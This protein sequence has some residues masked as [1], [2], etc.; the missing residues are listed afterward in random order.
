MR[1]IPARAWALIVLSALLQVMIF[2]VA[3]A[4]PVWRAALSWVALVPLLVALLL[5]D[6]AGKVFTMRH[7]G[8]LGYG[9][10]ILWYM[11][12]CYWIYPTMHE[13]GGLPESVSFVILILFSMYLG[14]YHA[15]FAFLLAWLRRSRLG[16]S[17]ALLLSP[18]V[19][20]S[21][22]LARSR[23]TYF[24]W[25]LLG[26]AQVD[27]LLLT[28]LAPLGGVMAI[29]FVLAG[30]NALVASYF[31]TGKKRALVYVGPALLI[32]LVV[33]VG[34][35]AGW[36]MYRNPD[37]QPDIAVMMQENIEVG[38]V[39]RAAGALTSTEELRQFSAWSLHPAQ[40][41][42]DNTMLTWDTGGVGTG[43]KPATVMVWPEAPAHLVSSDPVFRESMGQLARA[44]QAPLVIGSLGV[45]YDRTVERGYH[46]YDSA[47]YF[48]ATGKYQDRYDKIHLVPFGE[49][50]PF[51][52]LFSFAHKLTEGVGDTDRGWRRTLFQTGGHSYGTMICY[53]SV[54]GDEVRQFVNDG[55][56]VLVNI[57][58]DAWYGDSSAPWQT[59][60]M[61]RMR[62]IEN[63]RW[64]LR[65]TN[66]GITAAIDPHGRIAI[67]APRHVR[68]A[69]AFPFGF[70]RASERTLYTRD[71]DWF[72]GLCVLV[73]AMGMVFALFRRTGFELR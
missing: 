59:L 63:D 26:Y 64:V 32:I 58:N 5:G 72:A 43:V 12:N 44:G 8:L 4:L 65:D 33:Q 48:D 19:W 7:A 46:V 17:G 42:L 56:E 50:M 35:Y 10:G 53:E 25:D 40:T 28:R 62:A 20:V 69:F 6:S 1:L 29:S 57:S 2:P 49:Y 47:T 16:V 61:A 27:N 15:L 3:G 54:F 22:E 39:G 38:A 71:G 55:A 60:S 31:L 51:A 41:K 67:E 23:I 73:T 11:G 36:R 13:Y 34:G 30:I 70:K 18:F 37:A 45:D 68:A 21:V 14:L 52:K 24:P 9:C 66:T